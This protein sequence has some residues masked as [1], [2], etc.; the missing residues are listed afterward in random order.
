MIY[1]DTSALVPLFV[2]EA[3]SAAVVRWYERTRSQSELVS[4]VWCVTEFAS[5]LGLKQRVGAITEE[6]AGGA[7]MRFGRLVAADL[8]LLPMEPTVHYRAAE[9]TLDAASSL[10][11]GDA[12]HLACAEH[13]GATAMATL[14]EVLGRNALRLKIKPVAFEG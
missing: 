5:A 2:L 14:D 1:L 13:A 4:A 7:W 11:A 9:M 8:R 10:R 12:L 6:Q 3:T